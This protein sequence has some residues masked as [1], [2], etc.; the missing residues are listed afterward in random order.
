MLYAAGDPHYQTFD[1]R[2]FDFQG[3]CEYVLST[4]CDSDE[5]SVV[6]RN[7]LHNELVSCTDQVTVTGGGHT[8]VLGRGNGGTITIDGV[9]Q[10]NDGDRVIVENDD[11]Q[12]LRTGGHPNVLFPVHGVRVFYDGLYRVEVTVSKKWQDRLCG[13][14]GN[15]NGNPSDDLKD[16]E[17]NILRRPNDFGNSWIVGN[18]T[19]CVAPEE[20]FCDR[21]LVE[22][23]NARCAALS[24]KYFEPCNGVISPRFFQRNCVNDLC[25]CNEDD[26][27]KCYCESLATYAAACAAAGV[28][29][30][31]WRAFYNCRKYTNMYRNTVCILYFIDLL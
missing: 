10:P 23:A 29:L 14:C 7:E 17:G 9:L 2:N 21:N 1:L 27:E 6:V 30:P 31:D 25:F 12:V 13:L 11:V 15:Y 5:F 26:R 4:P 22:A 18:T 24:E 16:R 20:E 19:G 8:I 28:A 3:N